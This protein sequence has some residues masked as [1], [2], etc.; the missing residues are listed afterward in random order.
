M[1]AWALV[2]LGLWAI[3]LGYTSIVTARHGMGLLPLFFGDIGKLEWPGQFNLDFLLMLIVSASWTAWRNRFRLKGLALAVLAL[4]FGAGFLLPYLSYLIFR[5]R[6]DPTL[7]L[8]GDD[9]KRD[10]T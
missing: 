2:A 5:H 3:L 6:G 10:A 8:L 7:V 9:Y 4:G 1:R